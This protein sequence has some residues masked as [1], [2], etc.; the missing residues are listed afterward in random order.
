MFPEAETNGV[1][2]VVL[3]KTRRLSNGFYLPARIPVRNNTVILAPSDPTQRSGGILDYAVVGNAIAFIPPVLRAGLL[4]GE[5]ATQISSD[6]YP[7]GIFLPPP[8]E[9]R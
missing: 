3:C 8:G 7:V 1:I 4:F 2:I 6:H 9:P 5:R